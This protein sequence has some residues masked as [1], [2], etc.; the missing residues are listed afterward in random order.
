M[1]LDELDLNS[2]TYDE[3]LEQALCEL[4]RTK[5]GMEALWSF[6]RYDNEV[7]T[8]GWIIL[9]DDFGEIMDDT[10]RKQVFEHLYKIFTSEHIQAVFSYCI[11]E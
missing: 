6:I 10:F 9:L 5:E 7:T 3:D 2:A 11:D 4:P 1:T 8:E